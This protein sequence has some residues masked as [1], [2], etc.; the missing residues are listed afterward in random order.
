VVLIENAEERPVDAFAQEVGKVL[1]TVQD[2]ESAFAELFDKAHLV[3]FVF[4]R[5][6]IDCQFRQLFADRGGKAFENAATVQLFGC[7]RDVG[8]EGF[9]EKIQGFDSRTVQTQIAMA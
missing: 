3:A 9:P 7:G 2:K 4:I 5:N 1:K 6:D 8:E